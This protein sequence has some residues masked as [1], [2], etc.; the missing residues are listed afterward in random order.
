MVH[1]KKY[2]GYE[3]WYKYGENNEQIRITKEEFEEIK[4]KRGKQLERLNRNSN[5]YNRFEIMDI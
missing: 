5:K 1:F 2:N 4:T 3:V